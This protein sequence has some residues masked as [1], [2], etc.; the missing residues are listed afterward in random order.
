MFDLVEHCES[1]EEA[2]EVLM[3]FRDG[4]YDG[5]WRSACKADPLRGIDRRVK[6]TH[7]SWLAMLE[8]FG[9]QDR[10]EGC[11]RWTITDGFGVLIER[12]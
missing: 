8:A 9:L 3:N 4:D 1:R 10:S 11:L 7:R 5:F 2:I 12:G 6:W